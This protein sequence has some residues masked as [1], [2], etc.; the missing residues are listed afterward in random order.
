MA[1]NSAKLFTRSMTGHVEVLQ[2]KHAMKKAGV[3]RL[4]VA[5]TLRLVRG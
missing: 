4:S 3:K 2:G 1:Q 5:G